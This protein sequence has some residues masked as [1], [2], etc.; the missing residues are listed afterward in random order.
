[1]RRLGPPRAPLAARARSLDSLAARS[2]DILSESFRGTRQR[3]RCRRATKS[4]HRRLSSFRR[5]RGCQRWTRRR[6]SSYASS[7]EARQTWRRWWRES[8]S[9]VVVSWPSQRMLSRAG[10]KTILTHGHEC[11]TGS[12]NGP[13]ACSSTELAFRPSRGLSEEAV[14]G[15]RLNGYWR[16]EVW[17]PQLAKSLEPAI[18]SVMRSLRLLKLAPF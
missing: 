13:C 14:M 1:L 2:P 8:I 7:G 12:R 5:V 16:H 18:S 15:M 4:T 9:D 10:T 3:P 11:A 6:R 17:P